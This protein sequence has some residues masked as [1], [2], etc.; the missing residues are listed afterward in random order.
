[1][2]VFDLARRIRGLERGLR[3]RR[4]ATHAPPP[5]GSDI[6]GTGPHVESPC[7]APNGMLSPLSLLVELVGG[8]ADRRRDQLTGLSEKTLGFPEPTYRSKQLL[9]RAQVITLQ[10][11]REGIFS[12]VGRNLAESDIVVCP[13]GDV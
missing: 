13:L 10:I 8:C 7:G 3:H 4:L 12:Q 1:V 2:V 11:Y 9:T 6:G 5:F